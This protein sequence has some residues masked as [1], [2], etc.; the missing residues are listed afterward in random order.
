MFE[1]HIYNEGF[2]D[3]CINYKFIEEKKDETMKKRLKTIIF[4]NKFNLKFTKTQFFIRKLQ[5]VANI[6][7]FVFVNEDYGLKIVIKNLK[8]QNILH[9]HDHI[10]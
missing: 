3:F 2:C 8:I 4:F 5:N 10:L 9:H 6:N 7:K 1:Q